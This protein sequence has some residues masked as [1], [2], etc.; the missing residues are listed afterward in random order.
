MTPATIKAIL[1]RQVNADLLAKMREI[2]AKY[3]P[4][5]LADVIAHIRAEI[6]LDRWDQE[7]DDDIAEL[8]ARRAK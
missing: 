7:I 6:E 5:E 4:Q 1:N 2:Y 3:T 8:L